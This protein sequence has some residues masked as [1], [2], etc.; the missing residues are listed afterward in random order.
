M[1]KKGKGGTD[2]DR[3]FS[4]VISPS[5]RKFRFSRRVCQN[6]GDLNARKKGGNKLPKDGGQKRREVLSGGA[7]GLRRRQP[8]GP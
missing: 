7:A 8:G 1:Q 2:A 5:R 3:F 6:S 4:F